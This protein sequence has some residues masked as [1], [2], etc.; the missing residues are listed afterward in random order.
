VRNDKRYLVHQ[1]VT[2][3]EI[4]EHVVA[5]IFKVVF[6]EKFSADSVTYHY[7]NGGLA[8]VLEGKIIIKHKPM[9]IGGGET[10]IFSRL[11]NTVLSCWNV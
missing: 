2:H 1:K 3:R 10:N 6:V 5:S 8:F 9:R 4:S 7:S 11:S